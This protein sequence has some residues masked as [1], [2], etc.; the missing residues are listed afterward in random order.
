MVGSL[1]Q[2]LISLLEYIESAGEK[3]D[4]SSVSVETEQVAQELIRH[5][6]DLL[7]LISK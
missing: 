7:A 5:Q 4:N 2:L 1:F 3:V 6:N